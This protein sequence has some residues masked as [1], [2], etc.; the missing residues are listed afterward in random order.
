MT[1][2]N[3]VLDTIMTPDPAI[4]AQVN[5]PL[6]TLDPS[7]KMWNAN[8]LNLGPRVG[9]SY[10]PI[11]KTVVR[12]GYGV[13]FDTVELG[14]EIFDVENAPFTGS[15]GFAGTL[16]AP[17]SIDHLFP[18]STSGALFPPVKG[19]SGLL[20]LDR[21]NFK[22]PYVEQWN[23]GIERELPRNSVVE[24][25]YMGS[26]STHLVERSWASQGVLSNPGP[27]AKVTFL[28]PNFGYII[29]DSGST[30]SNYNAG[31]VRFEK[32]FD[33]GYSLLAFYTW[34]HVL[35]VNSGINVTGFSGDYPQNAWDIR[36]GYG[37]L[38]YD[39]TNNFVLSGLWE[40]PFGKG[41][42][43]MNNLSYAANLL[44][45][46]W[47]FNGIW[48]AQGGFPY[49]IA[50]PHDNSGTAW[51]IE[52]R[53]QLTG[54][55]LHVNN[56]LA[57]N[58]AAFAEPAPGTF[59]NESHAALRGLGIDNVD[60][61]MFKNNYLSERVNFQLRVESFN[62]FNHRDTGFYPNTTL[63][64]PAVGTYSTLDHAPRV[65]QVAGKI[66]F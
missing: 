1:E 8:R 18:V 13:Y 44:I 10:R 21:N 61:S 17:L 20:T 51:D 38:N 15:Y 7:N 62:V 35:G 50:A 24:V 32:K 5:S 37:S 46:G 64:S 12:A 43:L 39:V 25:S 63:S 2:L 59:G 19:S 52:P 14:E 56:G 36:A 3:P 66:I 27:N 49:Y 55:P 6:V 48:Q 4:V 22:T 16:A 60:F 33:S 53:A 26:S 30:S 58:P 34:S 42:A 54:Q 31:T 11:E 28:Y 23:L 57:F 9:F 45:G 41:K 65:L 47:Q 40:L 29:E